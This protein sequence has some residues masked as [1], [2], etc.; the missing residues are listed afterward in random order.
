MPRPPYVEPRVSVSR[1]S[2]R[3]N[4]TGSWKYIRPLYRDAVAPC[5]RACPAG[6]DVEGYLNLLRAG[7]LD[8]A[9]DLLLRENP[10]PAI[11]GRVCHH[12]CESGCNRRD[13]DEAVAVHSVERALG[14]H[15]L[16]YPHPPPL[17]VTHPERVAVVGAGPAGLSCAYHLARLG[18]AVTVF[19]EAAEAGGLLRQGIPAYR[20][21]RE[22]LD[23]QIARIASMGID[24]RTGVRLAGDAAR[25]E[26]DGYDAVFYATGAHRGKPMGVAGE[27]GPG[28]VAGLEFLKAVNRGARPDPGR[29]VAVIGG[30]N[31]AM[32][33][34]RT[35]LRLGA[36]PVVVYRRTRAEMPAI[37]Q[38]VD[39]A[40]R[41]GIEFVFLA[42][43]AAFRWED[44]R[45]V[46]MRVTRMA[47]GEPDSSGRRRPVPIEAGGYTIPVDTVL[48]AIGEDTE[49]DVL[50]ASL[51][52]EWGAI[53]VDDL[54]STG[55]G[56]IFAGGDL[57]GE[58]RTVA[59]ALGSGKRAAIG[60]HRLF[61]GRAGA[62][63]GADGDGAGTRG[64]QALRWGGTGQV[65]M[66]RARGDDPVRR[67]NPTDD[68]IDIEA[69]QLAHFRREPR[70]EDGV[71]D[72][73]DFGE[74][75]LGLDLEEAMAE[76][77][78][79]F[80]CGVCNDCELCL[81]LCPDVAITRR[82]GGG[83][84]IDLDYCKGCGVCAAECPRGAIVMTREGL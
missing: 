45:L 74:V 43:P 78:R 2:T 69:L 40:V 70:H 64:I 30:G 1:T 53:T 52:R 68:V 60:I 10:M 21:P 32:D 19:D 63:T 58:E 23:R 72:A 79:C 50:P 54:A 12:P 75:N 9:I 62:G 7:R 11:T 73:I 35:A 4:R 48:T 14:D 42:A 51:P 83:F 34:A 24:I 38:E 77:G 44:G 5:N 67:T 20:L 66:S 22:V 39:E 55:T 31:T 33:C 57:A 28:I 76:A 17:P 27:D 29:R 3:A 84:D 26:L 46:E 6:V 41:E 36:E 59:D 8:E 81:I 65:S 13:F 61:R 16:R 47:L 25:A 49:L 37:A 71:R 56:A 80:N 18:Y 82:D 15:A